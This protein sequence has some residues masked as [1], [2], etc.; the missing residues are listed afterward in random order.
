MIMLQKSANSS[1]RYVLKDRDTGEVLFV[2]VFT[3]LPQEQVEEGE[4]NAE[5]SRTLKA[6]E[7]GARADPEFEPKAD[8]LD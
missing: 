7:L 5:K 1:N 2:V 3:L 6:T 8:D 4:A